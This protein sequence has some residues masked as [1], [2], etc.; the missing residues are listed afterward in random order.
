MA[1]SNVRC[2]ETIGVDGLCSDF[3]VL[4]VALF[5]IVSGIWWSV[6]GSEDGLH[7]IHGTA[8]R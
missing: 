3:G 7:Y 1:V 2:C 5:W 6:Y 4:S 8:L